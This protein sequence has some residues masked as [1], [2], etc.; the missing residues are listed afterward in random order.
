MSGNGLSFDGHETY[1]SPRWVEK[2]DRNGNVLSYNRYFHNGEKSWE[3]CSLPSV[4][5]EF[6]PFFAQLPDESTLGCPCLH[7]KLF[8]RLSVNSLHFSYS[9]RR[10]RKTKGG[11]P[12]TKGCLNS[13]ILSPICLFRRTFVKVSFLFLRVWFTDNTSSYSVVT[14]HPIKVNER[15]FIF[16]YKYYMWLLYMYIIEITFFLS[17]FH[18]LSSQVY[19]LALYNQIW[20][21]FYSFSFTLFNHPSIVVFL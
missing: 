18:S 21:R 11:G 10:N 14:F 16:L 8:K 20:Y 19:L 13:S 9:P 4:V 6:L 15:I 12:S 3:E 7:V 17:F 5:R 2:V 1:F